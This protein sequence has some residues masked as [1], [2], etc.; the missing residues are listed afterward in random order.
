MKS[1]LSRFTASR[2]QI[3]IVA[4]EPKDCGNAADLHGARFARAWSDGEF[5]ALLGQEPVLGFVAIR[6]G[7]FVPKSLVGFVLAREVA[8][9][10]EI[11]SVAVSAQY[12]GLGLGWRLVHSAIREIRIRGG[13]SIFL[14]VDET[15]VAA[16]ALYKKLRFKQVG[17]R[18][19]YYQSAEGSKTTALVMRLDLG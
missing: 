12:S 11:L 6:S 5:H 14:E 3:D 13:K 4:M 16:L 10:A 7:L 8:G 18:K 19:G 9:E 2:A 17:E 1:L 15:N